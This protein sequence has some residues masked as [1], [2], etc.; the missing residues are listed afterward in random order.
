MSLSRLDHVAIEVVDLDQCIEQL[1][2]TGGMKLYRRGVLRTTGA[3]MAMVG[4]PIGTKL[5][6]IENKESTATAPRFLH[7]AFRSDDVE[8][9]SK[10]LVDKG[11]TWDHGPFEIAPAQCVSVN[12]S[13]KK[14]LEIQ[15]L[16]Y[17]P[18]SPD[19][20]EWSVGGT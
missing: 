5:E 14:G 3:R 8:A 10:A 9:T 7:L 6:I 2:G 17:Q 16:T 13:G 15:V 12:L 4:D 11:W 19:I 18:N 20:A 1:V